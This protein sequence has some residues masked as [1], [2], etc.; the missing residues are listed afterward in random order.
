MQIQTIQILIVV[1]DRA[2][3]RKVED[4]LHRIDKWRFKVQ[5]ASDLDAAIGEANSGILT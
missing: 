2:D 3:F 1:P 4:L 5:G